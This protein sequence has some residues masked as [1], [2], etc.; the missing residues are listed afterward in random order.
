MAA[1]SAP[2]SLLVSEDGLRFSPEITG[3]LGKRLGVEVA[4]TPGTHAAYHDHRTQLA[5]AVRPFL[6]EVTA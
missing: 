6:R 3:L 1:L 2:V 5:E 4:T